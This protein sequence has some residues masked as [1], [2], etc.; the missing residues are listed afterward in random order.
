MSFKTK[1]LKN[2]IENI[3]FTVDLLEKNNVVGLPTETVYGLGGRAD[4]DEVIKKYIVLNSDPL[5]IH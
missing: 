2:T 5:V 4:K 1:I 3:T